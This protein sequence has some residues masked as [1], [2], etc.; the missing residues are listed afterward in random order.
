MKLIATL[1]TVFFCSL[2]TALAQTTPQLNPERIRD[3]KA[4]YDAKENTVTITATAPSRTEYDWDT[5]YTDF[6]LDHISYI[7]I[8]RH[9]PG[10]SWPTEELGRIENP[11]LGKT[12]FLHRQRRCR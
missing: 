6:P 1:A 7:S 8:K 3:Q 2:S 11:E 10:T 4:S 5:Y 9:T 12:F